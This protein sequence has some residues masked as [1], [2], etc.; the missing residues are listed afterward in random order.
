MKNDAKQI[1]RRAV[2][3]LA[4]AF[5]K[6]EKRKNRILFSAVM[7]CV[8]VCFLV[9][10]LASGKIRTDTVRNIREDGRVFSAWLENGTEEDAALLEKLDYVKDTG[11]GKRAGK[12]FRDGQEA[13]QCIAVDEDTFVKM[14]LPAYTDFEGT[15]PEK[16]NEILMSRRMLEKLGITNPEIGMKIQTDFYWDDW[17]IS[18]NTGRQE[19]VLSGYYRDYC[20]GKSDQA[21]VYIS[22]KRLEES[23]VSRYP[24][25]VFLTVKQ[26]YFSGRQIE[27]RLYRDAELTMEQRFVSTDSA[28]FR[29]TEHMLGGFGV[30]VFLSVVILLSMFLLVYNVQLISVNRDVRQ[31]GMLEVLGVTYKDIAKIRNRQSL[32]VWLKGSLAGGAAASVLVLTLLP[33]LLKKMYLGNAGKMEQ[34]K[35][36]YPEL[37]VAAVLFSGLTLFLAQHLAVRK[38]KRLSP[39]EALRFEENEHADAGER[40]GKERK[41][42]RSKK[43]TELGRMAWRNVLR[44][45]KKFFVTVLSLFLG[46]EMGLCALALTDGTDL[47][48]KLE[49]NPDFNLRITDGYVEA[50]MWESMGI[51]ESQLIPE[52]AKTELLQI[53]G[54]TERVQTV[55]G[56][57]PIFSNLNEVI[58]QVLNASVREDTVVV[59]A[60]E[61]ARVNELCAYIEE[62]GLEID[63]ETW[64]NGAGYLVGHR[65]LA[66][67]DDP[68]TRKQIGKKTEGFWTASQGSM[69]D[70]EEKIELENC[71]Y[72]D[73][74]EKGVPDLG[75]VWEEEE[76]IYFFVSEQTLEY[77]KSIMPEQIFSVSFHVNKAEEPQIKRRLKSWVSEQNTEIRRL[78]TGNP[79]VLELICNSDTI[80]EQ[81]N[82][83]SGSRMVMLFISVILIFVGI[84]NYLNT[85]VAGIFARRK[86]LVVMESIGMTR[87]QLRRMLMLEGCCYCATVAGL[88]LTAGAGFLVVLEWIMKKRIPYFAYNFPAAAL[89]GM[90]IVLLTIC[91]LAPRSIYRKMVRKS[92]V[93]RLREAAQNG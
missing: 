87:K 49:Q 4:G 57:F 89:A 40:R 80:A 22:R 41:G 56:A 59:Q 51:A 43:G 83:M 55:R 76:I 35:V 69:A 47:I 8:S 5:E 78:G 34:V 23:G 15:Y 88:L 50:P 25:D 85:M 64:K 58:Y 31:Y 61:E 44:S 71:G 1:H 30:S 62:N 48:H 12:L 6:N 38:L 91:I 16:G 53:A 75:A 60:V 84:M 18:E 11:E 39:V 2:T 92:V 9:F 27:D 67:N 28:M 10:S 17:K 70:E 68:Y 29:A 72:L 32:K 79:E 81:K 42:R 52:K 65:H 93:E 66:R 24:A 45:R 90:M 14:I 77:M 26:N 36:F 86:E 46:C 82:Y 74:T 13:A 7:L 21:K 33:K 3:E 20:L 54:E 73:L 19:F 37:L 63:L